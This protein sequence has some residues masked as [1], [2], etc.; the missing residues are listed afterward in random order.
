[1]T[2]VTL[3]STYGTINMS[4]IDAVQLGVKLPAGGSGPL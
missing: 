3:N 1:M 2:N 4:S